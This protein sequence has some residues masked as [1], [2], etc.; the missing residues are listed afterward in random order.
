MKKKISRWTCLFRCNVPCEKIRKKKTEFATIRNQRNLFAKHLL[1]REQHEEKRVT[2]MIWH[3]MAV[4]VAIGSTFLKK[5]A[6][7]LA[8]VQIRRRESCWREEICR[9][10]PTKTHL[11]NNSINS[12]ILVR[13][14]GGGNVGGFSKEVDCPHSL[15]VVSPR[16]DMFLVRGTRVT[17][18]EK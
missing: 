5:N 8:A 7:Q 17:A 2:W 4:G 11:C 10:K 15:V 3:A 6:L 16:F 13:L 12:Y 14:C 1:R 9:S 18:L